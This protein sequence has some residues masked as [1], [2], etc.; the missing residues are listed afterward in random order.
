MG[1]VNGYLLLFVLRITKERKN[2]YKS[3][4]PNSPMYRLRAMH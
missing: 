1:I 4:M 2:W 3:A